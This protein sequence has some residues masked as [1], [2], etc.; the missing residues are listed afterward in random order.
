MTYLCSPVGDPYSAWFRR[1][2]F[3]VFFLWSTLPAYGQG[4]LEVL[5][6]AQ[7]QVQLLKRYEKSDSVLRSQVIRDSIYLP[8]KEF[9]DGY[10]GPAEAVADWHN[11]Q[12]LPRLSQ[13]E[14]SRIN[15]AQLV[16]DLFFTAAE[17]EKLTGYA[18]SGKWY[19]AYGPAWTDLGGLGKYAML[20]DLSHGSNSSNE[21]IAALFPHELT[22]QIMTKVNTH[23]DS[24]AVESIVGEGFAVWMNQ[25]YWGTKYTLEEHL[26]YSR[27][28]LKACDDNLP[29]LKMVLEKYKYIADADVVNVFRN[30]SS[31]I[32]AQLPGAIGYY[33]GYRVVQAYV[34]KYGPDSWKD[35]FTRPSREILEQSGFIQ[36]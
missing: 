3:Y 7:R 30:R 22:H 33:L 11:R 5:E 24:A 18:A 25:R 15:A 35:V 1:S 26:G 14:E 2:L 29:A 21:R 8:Y 12:L 16:K 19:I 28:E 13:L 17:M 32:H 31:R 27:E 6:L 4:K 9:W 10:L 20:I 23:G 34:A 36:P